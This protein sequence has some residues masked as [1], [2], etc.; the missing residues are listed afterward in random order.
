[1]PW[2]DSPRCTLLWVSTY[3]RDARRE[4][5]SCHTTVSDWATIIRT[6]LP[7]LSKPQATVLAVW[8]RRR[9]CTSSLRII[10]SPEKQVASLRFTDR[11]GGTRDDARP[12]VPH[13][14]AAWHPGVLC[15]PDLGLAPALRGDPSRHPAAPGAFTREP[16]LSWSHPSAVLRHL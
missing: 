5:M 13:T 3:L 15:E 11:G 4:V 8:L 7:Q 14:L 2:Q 10:Q 12:A 9:S 6:D 16:A 1:M